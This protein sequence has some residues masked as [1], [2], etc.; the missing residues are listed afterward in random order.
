[1][2]DTFKR[3]IIGTIKDKLGSQYTEREAE[4]LLKSPAKLKKIFGSQF[5]ERESEKLMIEKFPLRRSVN[6]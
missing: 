4:K 2:A 5:T 3:K 1:M 6:Y